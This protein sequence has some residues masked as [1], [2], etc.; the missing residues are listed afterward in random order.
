[1]GAILNSRMSNWTKTVGRFLYE[2]PH[3]PRPLIYKSDLDDDVTKTNVIGYVRSI[4]CINV[5]TFVC[6][7]KQWFKVHLREKETIEENHGN[8]Y[9]THYTY[10]KVIFEP[11]FEES[12]K[13]MTGLNELKL[14]PQ[15]MATIRI[16]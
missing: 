1:M 14:S 13:E 3:L 8:N 15:G 5:P 12:V 6:F 16:V 11:M 9:V 10:Q 7:Y 2:N 4:R